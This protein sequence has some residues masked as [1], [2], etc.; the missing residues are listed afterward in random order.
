VLILSGTVLALLLVPVLG[1]RLS[2][3]AEIDLRG[4]RLLAV[5]LL[6]QVL[7]ITVLTGAPHALRVALHAG[8]YLLA[9]AFLWRNRRLPGL[10]LLATGGGL[11]ALVIAVNGGQ[12]PASAEAVRRAGLPLEEEGFVNSGVLDDA[13]LAPLGDVFAS[14]DWLPLSNVYSPGDLLL[15][16]GA[17]WVV[18]AACGSAL[19]RG[20]RVLLRSLRSVQ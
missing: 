10:P 16:A 3:L 15:L 1:G 18:H 5:A 17:F 4:G 19:V 11:N 2:G 20:P 12:M 14:P 13:R 9:A 8:S 7:A 6:L